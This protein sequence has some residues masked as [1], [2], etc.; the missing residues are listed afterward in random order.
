MLFDDRKEIRKSAIK[1]ILHYRNN[2]A[3]PMQLRVYRKPIINF[4]CTE[5]TNMI[6]LNNDNILFEPPLTQS[7]PYDHLEQYL[8]YDE[9]PLPDPKI[10]VHIQATERH[11][12]LLASVS[13][14]VLPE[15]REAVMNV[16]GEPRKNIK[17]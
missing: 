3:D 9:P 7:I 15:S 16:I 13:K 8:E 17:I 10:P 4:N 6:D 12:Q 1:K 11:I 2:L 5:Y 14:R